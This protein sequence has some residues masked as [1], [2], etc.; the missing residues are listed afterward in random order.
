MEVA[1]V[2]VAGWACEDVFL[3]LLGDM[4]THGG[5]FVCFREDFID[6]L[7]AWGGKPV[8]AVSVYNFLSFLSPEKRE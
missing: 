1:G 8:R 6:A 4:S 2:E 7:R 5:V 3:T